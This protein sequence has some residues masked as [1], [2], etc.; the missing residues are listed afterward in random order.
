VITELKQDR[1]RE[2][3]FRYY[4]AEEEKDRISND[5]V[6]TE[7]NSTILPGDQAL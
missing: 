6:L 5:L 7:P 2:L 3:R 1:D 4:L